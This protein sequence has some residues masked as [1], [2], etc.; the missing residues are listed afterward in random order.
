M[1][2]CNAFTWDDDIERFVGQVNYNVSTLTA[3]LG[4]PQ[5]EQDEQDF[6]WL[7]A[8]LAYRPHGSAGWQR[9]QV[10][11]RFKLDNALWKGTESVPGVG[12]PVEPTSGPWLTPL[13]NS[14]SVD[15][16]NADATAN[17]MLDISALNF[18]VQAGFRY[19]F[20]FDI[21]Y[22]AAATTTGARFGINGPA[23]TELLCDSEYSLT[24]TTVTT[25]RRVT[26]YNEPAACNATSGWT[27]GNRAKISGWIKTSVSGFVIARFASKVSS[28]A[29]TVK[30]GSCVKY[31]KVA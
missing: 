24:T 15:V 17:T 1:A 25:N 10:I 16:Q 7:W 8:Q 12:D 21:F 14:I 18:P 23:L 9:S 11:K 26:A 4:Q 19:W 6:I 3:Q 2:A 20:E 13:M 5:G 30:A 27:T 31:A 29:I 22:D 28:S